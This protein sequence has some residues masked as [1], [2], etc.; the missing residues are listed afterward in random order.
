[1]SGLS[2]DSVVEMYDETRGLPPPLMDRVVEALLEI[3]GPHAPVLDV[4]VGTGRFA[5]PLQARGLR[6]VGADIAPRMLARARQKGC[7]DLVLATAPHLPFRDGAF[8]AAAAIHFLHLVAAWRDAVREIARV[9]RDRFVT[10]LET[11]TTRPVGSNDVRTGYGPGDVYHPVRH[12]DELARAQGYVYE[13]PGV[14]PQDL[15]SRI[16]PQ[17]RVHAGRHVAV[18]TGEMLL[19]PAAAKSYSSQWGVPDDIHAAV[20]EELTR[21]MSGRRY[22]RTWEVEVIAW[23]PAAMRDL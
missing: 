12:Y 22:E 16:L 8:G 15:S 6:V 18:L 4:G 5:A 20:I 14:R 21:E 11:V 10:L 3:L 23:A 13:H 1:M 19:A 9:T 17:V 2:F 7:R